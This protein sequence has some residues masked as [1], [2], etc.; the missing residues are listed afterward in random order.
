MGYGD[1]LYPLTDEVRSTVVLDDQYGIEIQQW[2]TTNPLAMVHKLDDTFAYDLKGNEDDSNAR[3]FLC[4]TP[5]GWGRSKDLCRAFAFAMNKAAYLPKEFT[6]E[7]W[8]VA[9]GTSVDGMG[10]FGTKD[11]FLIIKI[12]TTK[13]FHERWTD[14]ICSLPNIAQDVL[15]MNIDNVDDIIR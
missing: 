11:D 10:R 3:E 13:K 8:N 14:Y 2:I 12:P 15:T 1:S 4:I 6:V 7:I 5:H 9:K